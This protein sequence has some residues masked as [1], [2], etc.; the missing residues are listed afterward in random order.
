MNL[1]AWFCNLSSCH[2]KGG[3]KS[4]TN[5]IHGHT[6][7]AGA[8]MEGLELQNTRCQSCFPSKHHLRLLEMLKDNSWGY[9]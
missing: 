7:Q 3:I 1:D 9:A 4:P 6:S 8:L 5:P 2:P